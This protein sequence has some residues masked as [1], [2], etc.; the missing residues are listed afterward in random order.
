MVIPSAKIL[1]LQNHT[2]IGQSMMVIFGFEFWTLFNWF[3][4]IGFKT[5]TEIQ[6]AQFNSCLSNTNFLTLWITISIMVK[7]DPNQTLFFWLH[8]LLKYIVYL[9]YYVC[10]KIII[11]LVE[12]RTK[13]SLYCCLMTLLIR[14]FIIDSCKLDFHLLY[15]FHHCIPWSQ[16]SWLLVS[17]FLQEVLLNKAEEANICVQQVY[18]FMKWTLSLL[19]VPETPDCFNIHFTL[20][21]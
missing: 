4:W 21:V 3:F 15:S 12:F 2:A 18:R 5:R 17:I 6:N 7:L 9:W 1:M 13:I 20:T 11:H 10:I 16:I 19:S 14:S 8:I